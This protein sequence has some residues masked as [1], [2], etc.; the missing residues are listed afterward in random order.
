MGPLPAGPTGLFPESS[1]I[2]DLESWKNLKSLSIRQNRAPECAKAQKGKRA[3]HTQ[4]LPGVAQAR[5]WKAGHVKSWHFILRQWGP[6]MTWSRGSDATQGVR[7]RGQALSSGWLTPEPM[8]FTQPHI[9]GIPRICRG[10]A[11]G[12][13]IRENRERQVC[14]W[15]KENSSI[16]LLLRSGSQWNGKMVKIRFYFCLSISVIE[17]WISQCP[18]P[19]EPQYPHLCDGWRVK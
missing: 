1:W 3:G 15:L 8:T 5:A 6:L 16:D 10:K 7:S 19:S 12:K 2:T 17:H 13:W 11:Q 18:L 4:R 9:C 14:I